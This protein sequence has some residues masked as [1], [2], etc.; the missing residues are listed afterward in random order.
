MDVDQSLENGRRFRSAVSLQ[1]LQ[2]GTEII[3]DAENADFSSEDEDCFNEAALQTF[4]EELEKIC[5]DSESNTKLDISSFEILS[6]TMNPITEDGLL[7]KLEVRPG[8]GPVIPPKSLVLLHYNAYLEKQSVPFDSTY[9]RNSPFRFLLGGG[10]VILGLEMGVATMKKGEVAVFLVHHSYAFGPMGCPPRV[11]PGATIYYEVEILSYIDSADAI[12]YEE[13]TLEEQRKAP[14]DKILSACKAEHQMGNSLYQRKIY[15]GAA[16]RYRKAT[17]LLEDVCVADEEEDNQRQVL[18]VKLYM[19]LALC[20]LKLKNAKRCRINALKVL[21]MDC[22]GSKTKA[23]FTLGRAYCLDGEYDDALKCL[24]RAQSEEP[25]NEEI[26]KQ[27]SA[28]EKLQKHYSEKEKA[29]CANIFGGKTDNNNAFN[30]PKEFIN[31]IIDCVNSFKESSD[32]EYCLPSGY[33]ESQI[34]DIKKVAALNSVH[35]IEKIHDGNKIC[36]LCK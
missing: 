14:F 29:F 23:L 27:I 3:L 19:N 36:K 22:G 5:T 35:F 11:P 2:E 4:K 24:Y 16:S 12:E 15:S 9:Q 26:N 25:F 10:K 13:M 6:E 33:T 21:K 7:R 20:Y 8:C 31:S 1:S 34:E 30:E 28:T 32:K 17:R 18:L